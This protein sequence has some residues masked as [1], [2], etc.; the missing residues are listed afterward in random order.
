MT[1]HATQTTGFECIAC[2]GVWVLLGFVAGAA[3]VAGAGLA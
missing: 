1:F 2:N 3:T